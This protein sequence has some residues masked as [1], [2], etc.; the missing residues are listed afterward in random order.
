M[1][2]FFRR[3][4]LLPGTVFVVAAGAPAATIR[5]AHILKA[6]YNDLIQICDGTNDEV[7]ILAAITAVSV[8]GGGKV[9][10]SEG[11]F[12]LDG[13]YPNNI[14]FTGTSK[15]TLT[16]QGT[17]TKIFVRNN[18]A[19]EVFRMDDCS[20]ITVEQLSVDFDA[21]V[22]AVNG[23]TVCPDPGKT[24]HHITYR[25]IWIDKA[26]TA[27]IIQLSDATSYDILFEDIIATN[28]YRQGVWNYAT[29]GGVDD[30]DC[31]WNVMLQRCTIDTVINDG[32]ANISG[33]GMLIHTGRN[34]KVIDCIVKN[35]KKDGM[36]FI[37]SAATYLKDIEIRGCSVSDNGQGELAAYQSGIKI[38][39]YVVGYLITQCR[40]FDTRVGAAKTQNVGI[41]LGVNQ[42]NGIVSNNWCFN[43]EGDG[44]YNEASHHTVISS[45]TVFTNG[46]MGIQCRASYCTITGNTCRENVGNGIYLY[47]FSSGTCMGNTC[48]KNGTNG[49]QESGGSYNTIANNTCQLNGSDGINIT[50]G[51]NII[52][53]GNIVL[54]SNQSGGARDNIFLT[55]ATDILVVNNLVRKGVLANKPPYGIRIISTCSKI[56]IKNNDLETSGNAANILDQAALTASEGNKGL[57]ASETKIYI[58]MDNGSGGTL[59]AGDV[60]ILKK[61]ANPVFV[62]TTVTLGDDLVYGMIA[63][64]ILN[65]AAG[66]VLVEGYT[67]VLKFSNDQGAIAIGDFLTCNNVVKEAALAVAGDMGFAIALEVSAVDT[68]LNAFIVKP[69]K[70]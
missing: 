54:E 22:I 50:N 24:A 10:L 63:E 8:V 31:V 60:V 47:S 52:L 53:S 25:R 48:Y 51:T 34:T 36:R 16:G 13:A 14:N 61:D 1:T 28:S 37:G 35:A 59:D 65:G 4:G 43:N 32:A 23:L 44:I 26:M 70:I 66:M 29:T 9:V 46:A 58:K 5:Q 45:N 62:N 15:I 64:T 3:T 42:S 41:Y 20:Y 38:H 11:T 69:R 55:G 33:Y 27:I 17:A 6:R 19:S 40:A 7:E 12:N 2:D 30:A 56:T 49:I 18:A 21:G 68:T 67:T 39:S 57:Y